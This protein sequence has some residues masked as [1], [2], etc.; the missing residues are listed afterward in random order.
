M[1][2][3]YDSEVSEA[4]GEVSETSGTSDASVYKFRID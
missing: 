2:E 3:D 1:V 4:S